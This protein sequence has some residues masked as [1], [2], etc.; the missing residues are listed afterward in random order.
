MG[1]QYLKKIGSLWLWAMLFEF[2]QNLYMAKNA[3][4][5]TV[6]ENRVS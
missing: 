2:P 5:T 4:W 6:C 1:Y 3:V